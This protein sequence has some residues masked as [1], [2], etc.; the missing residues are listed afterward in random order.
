MIDLQADFAIGVDVWVEAGAALVRSCS[1]NLGR[2]A[3][4]LFVEDESKLSGSQRDLN[5]SKAYVITSTS[6]KPNS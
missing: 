1:L 3:R 4:V 5:P 2:F 6:K